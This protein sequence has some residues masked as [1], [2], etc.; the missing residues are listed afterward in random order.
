[1]DLMSFVM[2]KL[3]RLFFLFNRVNIFFSV[4]KC[5][6]CVYGDGLAPFHI[7]NAI[8]HL[9]LLIAPGVRPCRLEALRLYLYPNTKPWDKA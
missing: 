7:F 1:M 2:A 6:E 8:L 3:S 5:Q 4:M 9:A